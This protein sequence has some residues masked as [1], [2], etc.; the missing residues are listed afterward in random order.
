MKKLEDAPELRTA[1]NNTLDESI[2]SSSDLVYQINLEIAEHF[3][4]AGR[5]SVKPKRTIAEVH[6]IDG[7][8]YVVSNDRKMFSWQGNT[9]GWYP[10][11]DLPQ[12]D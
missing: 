3:F 2:L 12:E 7:E 1:F 5:D 11:P 10:L 6:E 4:I 9:M 8:I